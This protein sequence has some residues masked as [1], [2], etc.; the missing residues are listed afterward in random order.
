MNR[1]Y[2]AIP[3]DE[4]SLLGYKTQCKEVLVQYSKTAYAEI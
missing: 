2:F 1:S 3:Y 4:N